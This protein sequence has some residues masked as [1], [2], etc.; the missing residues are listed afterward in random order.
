[1]SQI[2]AAA[3]LHAQHMRLASVQSQAHPVLTHCVAWRSAAM[4]LS[5][6][7]ATWTNT[8]LAMMRSSTCRRS[9]FA[10]CAHPPP[11]KLGSPE[12]WSVMQ[13]ALQRWV[14]M[15]C[16]CDGL[17]PRSQVRSHGASPWCSSS[18]LRC[19]RRP[20][21]LLPCSSSGF[22]NWPREMSLSQKT[23]LLAA[24]VWRVC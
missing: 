5:A 16:F 13:P 24:R 18:T 2:E 21:G 14:M 11:M 7:L 9:T 23:S 22:I 12:A 15:R 10:G 1:M 4:A 6:P 17:L 8:G 20:S 3:S 19:R